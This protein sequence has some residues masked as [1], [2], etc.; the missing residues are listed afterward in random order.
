MAFKQNPGRLSFSK[1]GHGL[2]S[3]LKQ[4]AEGVDPSKKGIH[5]EEGR[6]Y[7][8]NAYEPSTEILTSKG[9]KTSRLYRAASGAVNAIKKFGSSE[10]VAS[11]RKFKNDSTSTMK[12]REFNAER[13]NLEEAADKAIN[14]IDKKKAS[15]MKQ[16]VSKKVAYDIK[17]ASNQ[18]MKPS[19]RKHYAE[20]AQAAMK[21][22]K[23]K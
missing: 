20:N 21:N 19:A 4:M 22:K 7:V 9:E 13:A 18:K 6:G 5:K 10:D 14:A 3:A 17:E 15:P 8:P 12:G 16:S 1:T 11:Y 23:K 2:P